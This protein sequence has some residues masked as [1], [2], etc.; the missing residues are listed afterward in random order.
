MQG[1][2]EIYAGRVTQAFLLE[3]F[4]PV[5]GS[6]FAGAG[7]TAPRVRIKNKHKTIISNAIKS[8][9]TSN[10]LFFQCS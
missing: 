1:Y 9:K 5:G 7:C 3:N 10:N 2:P 6:T 8:N 4:R